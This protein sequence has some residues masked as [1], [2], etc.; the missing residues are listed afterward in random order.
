MPTRRSRPRRNGRRRTPAW[1]RSPR[2]RNANSPPSSKPKTSWICCARC[3]IADEFKLKPLLLGNGYEYRVRKALAEKKTPIIL[4][5]D[6]PKVPE[7]E[8]PEQAVEYQ[9]DELQHW[10]RAP[11][12]AARLAEAGIPI[13]FTTE[14]LEKPDKEFWSRLRLS[15]RRGLSK[16]AALAALTSTPAEMFGVADRMGT[17]APGRMANLVIASGDLFQRGSEGADDVGRRVLLRHANCADDRDLRGTWEVTVDGKTLP[18]VVEGEADKLEAKLARRESRRIGAR[19]CGAAGRAGE[20][21][22]R[23]RRRR[24]VVRSPRRRCDQREPAMRLPEPPFAGVQSARLRTSPKKP[25]RSRRR[26]I[27][28]SIFQRPIPAGAFGRAAPPELPRLGLDSR[29]D[30]LDFSRARHAAERGRAGDE[31][32]NLGGRSGLE[33]AGRAPA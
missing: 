1:P 4:P 13:A 20:V 15:V 32:Q 30:G 12:N 27:G 7:I 10:D 2:T 33:S 21:V 18:L 25:T 8:R 22:W 9:L 3:E 23:R 24:A 28:R 11:S 26:A 19:G 31:R 14:K 16:D 5:L 6:F 29:R 17:I